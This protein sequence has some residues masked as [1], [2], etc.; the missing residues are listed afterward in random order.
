M[1]P[2][3]INFKFIKFLIKF[4][5]SASTCAFA[6]E[7]SLTGWDSIHIETDGGARGFGVPRL[8]IQN[9]CLRLV[10]RPCLSFSASLVWFRR[11]RLPSLLSPFSRSFPSPYMHLDP[12]LGFRASLR[13]WMRCYAR[14][15]RLIYFKPGSSINIVSAS[16]AY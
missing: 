9:G 7:V 10:R 13:G 11:R 4:Y 8:R 3:E 6:W 16:F 14:S 15:W 12:R 5:I 2:F 1:V